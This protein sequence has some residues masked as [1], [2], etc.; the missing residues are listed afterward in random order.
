MENSV[1]NNAWNQLSPLSRLKDNERT[2]VEGIVRSKFFIDYGIIDIVNDDM[3]V[4]V[5]HAALQVM[6]DGTIL[7]ATYTPN[8]EM[9]FPSSSGFEMSWSYKAGD[10]VLLLAMK[11]YIETTQ[12]TEP[13]VPNIFSHFNQENIKAL[14]VKSVSGA[15]AVQIVESDGTL[16]VTMDDDFTLDTGNGLVTIK[17]GKRSLATLINSLISEI[18]NLQTSGLVAPTTII[19]AAPGSPC[20]GT[21]PAIPISTSNQTNLTTIA[22]Q[23]KELLQ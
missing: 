8:I 11:D 16:S 6:R 5:K 17:N 12:I 23:F 2:I 4:N 15:A 7:E 19:S 20:T 10:T 1:Q 21:I 3:T 9:L 14:L 22:N 13:S 18:K